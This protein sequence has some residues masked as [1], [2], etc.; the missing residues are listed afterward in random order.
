MDVACEREQRLILLDHAPDRPAA[1]RD[2]VRLSAPHHHR[3]I[4]TELGRE[5]KARVVRGHVRV[6]DQRVRV[7]GGLEQRP[8]VALDLLLGLL[9]RGVPRRRVRPPVAGDPVPV[10]V[11]DPPVVVL[12]DPGR[13]EDVRDEAL[14]VV[15]RHHETGDPAVLQPLVGELDPPL[16]LLPHR[17]AEGP[18]DRRGIARH[19]RGLLRL[20]PVG[21]EAVEPDQP[22][23]LLELLPLDLVVP[24]HERDPVHLVALPNERDERLPGDVPGEHERVHAVEATGVHELA[25]ADLGPVDVGGHEQADHRWPHGTRRPAAEHAHDAPSVGRSSDPARRGVAAGGSSR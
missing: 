12:H 15:P 17:G 8:Q 20:A 14:V 21:V 1:D 2:L 22:L 18:G 6:E 19:R 23:D 9:A 24:A 13:V 3:E 10:D 7:A 16:H 11:Q 5:V 25:E 4:R